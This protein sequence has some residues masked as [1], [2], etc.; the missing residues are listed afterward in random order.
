MLL[1][2]SKRLSDVEDIHS[3]VQVHRSLSTEDK[4]KLLQEVNKIRTT[5]RTLEEKMEV[6]V[7][8]LVRNIQTPRDFI[9]CVSHAGSRW[10][11]CRSRVYR[12]QV[13]GGP[14]IDHV[15][16]MCSSYIN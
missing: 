3:E 14:H 11:T 7:K 16:F 5:W 10:S 2:N 6:A 15:Q 4:R 9:T 12:M 1:S 13:V 8:K